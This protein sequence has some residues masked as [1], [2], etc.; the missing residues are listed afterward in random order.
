[1]KQS[2]KEINQG[3][4]VQRGKETINK[5]AC[6]IYQSGEEPDSVGI[7]FSTIKIAYTGVL[8]STPHSSIVL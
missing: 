3:E 5:I 2:G 6:H 8:S 1:M 7:S 4:H